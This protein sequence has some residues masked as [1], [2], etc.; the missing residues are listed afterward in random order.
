[1]R[2]TTDSD[3]RSFDAW[4]GGKDILERLTELENEGQINLAEIENFCGM[5]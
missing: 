2:I 5:M 3:I 1:M 4:S